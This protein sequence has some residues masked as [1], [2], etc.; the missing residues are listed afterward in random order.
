MRVRIQD[1]AKEAKVSKSTVSLILNNKA[2]HIPIETRE[3]IKSISRKMGYRP[4]KIAKSLSNN[5]T[6]TIGVIVPDIRN[7]FFADLAKGVEEEAFL[8]EYN[9]FLCNSDDSYEKEISYIKALS[10][11]GVD[12][13][14][15]DCAASNKEKVK[16]SFDRLYEE[17]IPTVLVDRNVGEKRFNTV[18]FNNIEGAYQAVKYLIDLGHTKIGCVTGALWLDCDEERLCGYKKA[19]AE[20]EIPYDESL[21][22]EGGYKYEEGGLAGVELVKR[23]VTAIFC[24]DDIMAYGLI[25]ELKKIGIKVP[26]D[27]SVVGFDSINLNHVPEDERITTIIQ[28]T[29]EMGQ[30]AFN[31]LHQIMKDSGTQ[32]TVKNITISGAL[33]LGNSTKKRPKD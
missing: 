17:N 2:D 26:R 14:I 25:Y 7:V 13:I 8:N 5:S 19:L 1:I 16:E 29:N 27:L 20:K 28:P 9:V 21:V 10:D 15:L 4:N 3:K 12:G 18:M 30:S 6:N 22:I 31:Q 33:R 23:G 32:T 24:Y 11:W